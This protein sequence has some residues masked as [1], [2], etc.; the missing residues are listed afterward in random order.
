LET[1]VVDSTNDIEIEVNR[2]LYKVPSW[3]QLL[4]VLNLSLQEGV[5]EEGEKV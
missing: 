1:V 2:V 4:D 5:A 3:D